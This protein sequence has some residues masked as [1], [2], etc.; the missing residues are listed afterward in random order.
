MASCEAVSFGLCELSHA[1]AG[2]PVP[3]VASAAVS[4][5]RE[6]TKS[7]IS[8]LVLHYKA[9]LPGMILEAFG[10]RNVAKAVELE[11]LGSIPATACGPLSR[12]SRVTGGVPLQVPCLQRPGHGGR[13]QAVPPVRAA[14][15][16]AGLPHAYAP[17]GEEA[18]T[19]PGNGCLAHGGNE[20]QED[21]GSDSGCAQGIWKWGVVEPSPC[22]VGLHSFPSKCRSEEGPSQ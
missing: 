6:V 10:V 21:L 3:S 14:G 7:L 1:P 15:L 5:H 12:S 4:F 16:R 17:L 8:P 9:A 11:A 13:G 19:D 22:F 2:P 20:G 18:P